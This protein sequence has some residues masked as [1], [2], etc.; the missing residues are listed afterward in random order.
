[1]VDGVDDGLDPELV[2]VFRG[3]MS[4]ADEAS[5]RVLSAM[6]SLLA[7]VAY[8]DGR[9]TNEERA[10]VRAELSLVLGFGEED[11]DAICAVLGDHIDRLAGLPPEPAAQV[12]RKHFDVHMRADAVKVLIEL[13]GSDRDFDTAEVTR[14]RAVADFLAVPADLVDALLRRAREL[15]G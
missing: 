3:R 5:I 7:H 10:R 12:L 1:M 14:I 11:L 9:Y 8:A 2:G 6:T 13:A 15:T 4:G